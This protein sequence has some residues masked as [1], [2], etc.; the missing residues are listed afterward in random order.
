VYYVILILATQAD[1]K[2]FVTAAGPVLDSIQ[3]KLK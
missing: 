3:W 1:V 2:A